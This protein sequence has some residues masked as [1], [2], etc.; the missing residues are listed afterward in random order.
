MNLPDLL[1]LPLDQ[2]TPDV[3]AAV[4]HIGL[5]DEMVM[6]VDLRN[7]LGFARGRELVRRGVIGDPYASD[8]THKGSFGLVWRHALY[9]LEPG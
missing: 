6:G 7:V 3:R 4:E 9:D 8:V 5:I 2:M 1:Y